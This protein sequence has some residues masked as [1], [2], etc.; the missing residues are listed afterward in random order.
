[1]RSGRSILPTVEVL[2]SPIANVLV[3]SSEQVREQRLPR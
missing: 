3:E 1:M 2:S